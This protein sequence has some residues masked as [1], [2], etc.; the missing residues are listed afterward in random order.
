MSIPKVLVTCPP[1]LGLFDEFEEDF[2]A[3]GLEGVPANV[4]QTMS[5][6][7]LMTTLPNYDAWIIGDD[8]ASARVIEHGGGS[9]KAAIKWGVGTD[10]V[11]FA[12]FKK[13]GIPITNTPGVFGH[14]V[15]DVAMTYLIGL[16]RETYR[17]DREIRSK[18]GWPK[19]SGISPV[20][21]TAAI[22]GYG[23]IGRQTVT[24]LLACGMNVIIYDP[25][26][27]EDL[28]ERT[29]CAPWPEQ[30][31]QADFLVFTCPLNAATQGMFDNDLL[32]KLRSGVRVINVGRGPVIKEKALLEGLRSGIVHSAALDVFEVEPL[33]A[34]S[35]LRA[36]DR[37][38]FGSHNG[39]NSADAVRRVSKLAI[40]LLADR[41]PT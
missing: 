7:E 6:D 15:A 39:S 9:L 40:R 27:P 19:P 23:D 31:D 24:R 10:N 22:V 3:H 38:I 8:P 36:F 37:C 16:A 41:M 33:A 25:A 5:E 4:T 1:M 18:N 30:I 21:R 28:P 35:E 13:A 26:A 12:A 14:E 29:R 20:G 32:A 17:I 34:D 2:A 11:D